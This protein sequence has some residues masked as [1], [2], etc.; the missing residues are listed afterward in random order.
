MEGSVDGVDAFKACVGSFFDDVNGKTGTRGDGGVGNEPHQ[1]ILRE[2][3]L[4]NEIFVLDADDLRILNGNVHK[5]IVLNEMNDFKLQYEEEEEEEEDEEEANCENTS[6]D[7]DDGLDK[8][9][10]RPEEKAMESSASGNKPSVDYRPANRVIPDEIN[11]VDSD[12]FD[13]T[14]YLYDPPTAYKDQFLFYLLKFSPLLVIAVLVLYIAGIF[15]N[16]NMPSISLTTGSNLGPYMTHRMFLL[17]EEIK[18]L[19]NSQNRNGDINSIQNQ[20]DY[21]K[22]CID[23]LGMQPQF[24]DNEQTL[25]GKVLDR[26]QQLESTMATL[27]DLL[28]REILKRQEP[29]EI[30]KVRKAEPK[31]G[32]PS[33][34]FVNIANKLKVIRQLTSYPQLQRQRRRKT[35]ISRILYG[36]PDFLRRVSDSKQSST[37]QR[38]VKTL[39]NIKLLSSL[40]SP[41][42]TLC[43]NPTLFWQNPLSSTP[44]YLTLTRNSSKPIKLHEIGIYHS[45]QPPQFHNMSEFDNAD[46]RNR[47]LKT[48]PRNVELLV[49]PMEGEFHEMK[50]VLGEHYNQDIQ[51]NIN[52]NSNTKNS[53]ILQDWIRIGELEYDNMANKPYQT[54]AWPDVLKHEIQRFNILDIMLILHS[55]WGDEIIVLDAVRVFESNGGLAYEYPDDI[56]YPN[57]NDNNDIPFLGEE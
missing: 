24:N 33:T 20:I 17:E 10:E 14:M 18:S 54:F 26:I 57:A 11:D 8:G 39:G 34:S 32:K 3:L 47:W 50:A 27:S 51:F 38:Q 21:L 55:N 16:T 6:E 13:K 4:E 28:N 48:A 53:N 25:S 45:R 52:L 44:I 12:E 56:G 35:V 43:E 46:L 29:E 49:R 31:R 19:K 7:T 42:N 9:Y 36:F 30:I 22:D 1:K 15:G 23:N 40:N 41:K 37:K 2:E 5:Q